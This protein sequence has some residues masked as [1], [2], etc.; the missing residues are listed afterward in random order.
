MGTSANVA[1]LQN[2]RLILREHIAGKLQVKR[3]Y[4]GLFLAGFPYL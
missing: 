2:I 1:Y 3:L 4:T